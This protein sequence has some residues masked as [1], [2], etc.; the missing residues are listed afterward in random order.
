[1]ELHVV[2][3]FGFQGTVSYVP[4]TVR[5]YDEDAVA[6]LHRAVEK[7]HRWQPSVVVTGEA[8]LG[9]PGEVLA[10]ESDDASLLVVGSRGR[11]AV[12]RV[13]LGSVSQDC[14]HRSRCAVTIVR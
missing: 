7:V 11:G 9:P 2:H 4:V 8:V 1:V 13:L 14:A 6:L 5:D 10:A 3:T 12:K